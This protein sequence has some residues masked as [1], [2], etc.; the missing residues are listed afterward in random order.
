MSKKEKLII[1]QYMLDELMCLYENMRSRS[2]KY[3]DLLTLRCKI[4]EIKNVIY[5]FMTS[6]PDCHK[7]I[8]QED[9]IIEPGK[10]IEIKTNMTGYPEDISSEINYIGFILS[11]GCL[12][13]ICQFDSK[14]G[15]RFFM[16]SITSETGY[17]TSDY[18]F[19]DGIRAISPGIYQ[20]DH[21]V[22]IGIAFAKEM[23]LEFDNKNKL[24]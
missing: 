11:R 16:K 14:E 4:K 22:T 19:M 7:V 23:E 2:H 15:M 17:D 8:V 3:Q 20:I 24:S 9:C 10:L 6:I 18:G 13:P 21:G 1:L 12:K 5:L